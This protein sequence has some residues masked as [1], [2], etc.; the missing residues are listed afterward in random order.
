MK[1]HPDRSRRERKK[2]ARRSA[3]YETA[4]ELFTERG[5]DNVSVEEITE[6][7]DV[8]KG[9]FFNYFPTKVDVLLEY[10]RNIYDAMH[11]YAEGLEG[12]ERAPSLPA[13]LSQAGPPHP[14]RG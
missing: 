4:L 6:A 7:V 2:A 8:S 12:R 13:V 9:T 1:T 10:R 11:D 5:F 14:S 3:I